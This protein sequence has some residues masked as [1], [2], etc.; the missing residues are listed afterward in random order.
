M[1]TTKL[2]IMALAVISL[3]FFSCE[4]EKV[5]EKVENTSHTS[6][7]V[8][9][10]SQNFGTLPFED[11][12]SILESEQS[13]IDISQI[14]WSNLEDYESNIDLVNSL[15][16]VLYADYGQEEIEDFFDN[17]GPE[18]YLQS[19]ITWNEEGDQCKRNSDGTVD[20]R[21]CDTFWEYV[22][23]TVK[24]AFCPGETEEMRYDCIQQV[25]CDHC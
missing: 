24:G 20:A 15:M 18:G 2:T 3:S 17:L 14:D 6:N 1:K 25:V 7:T 8:E 5:K 13:I 9:F 19:G 23:F 22:T 11:Q 10:D 12:V 21:A 16:A 4:K